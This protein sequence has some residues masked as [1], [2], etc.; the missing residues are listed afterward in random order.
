MRFLTRHG[1][2]ITQIGLIAGL[3]LSGLIFLWIGSFKMPDL[4]AF[5]QRKVPQ[6]TKIYDRTGEVLLYDVHED[7]R[8]TVIPFDKMSRHIKN[9]TVAIEDAEFYEHNGIKPTAILRAVLVNLVSLGYEQGGSTITQQVVKNSLLT[10]EKTIT[11]K[12]KEWVLALRLEKELPKDKILEIYLNEAPYGGSL[13]GIEE[14]SQAFFAKPAAELTLVESAYLAALPQ[15]PTYYSPY[16]NHLDKLEERKNLV[17]ESM[18]ENGFITQEEYEAALSE[19]ITFRD[20]PDTG[21]RAPHFVFYVLDKLREKYGDRAIEER[22]FRVIT[23]LDWELQEKAEQIVHDYAVENTEKF[24]ANNAG[25]AAVDPKTGQI[26]VMVG[27]RDYFDTTEEDGSAFADGNFN[28]TTGFRQPGSAFKPIVYATALKEGYTPE[29]VVFDVPTQFSTACE[30]DNFTSEGECYSPQNYDGEF[31]G[32]MTL[33]NALA[34]SV[35]VPAV[36]VLYLAGLRDALA[37]AKDLGIETLTT[38]SRYGLTLVLGGGEVTLLDLTSAYGVFANEGIR[39]PHTPILRIEDSTG[40]VVEE[41]EETSQRVLDESVALQ[42]SDILSD[43]IARTP[44]Y[45]ANS[46]LYFGGRDVAVKT[47]T[48]NEYV[49]VWT[50][51][52][53][54]SIAVGAWAGNNDSSSMDHQLSGLI[55]TPLWR[56]FMDEALKKYPSESFREPRFEDVAT[57]KPILRGVWQGGHTYYIDSESGKLASDYTPDETRQERVLNN[58]HSILYWVDKDNPRGPIPD[59]PAAD[60]QF[61][62]WEYGVAVWKA[63]AGIEDGDPDDIPTETDDVHAPGLVELSIESPEENSTFA[64]NDLLRISLTSSGENRLRRADYYVDGAFIGSS[65]RSPFSFSFVPSD[66]ELSKGS[67]TLKVIGKDSRSNSDEAT[68]TFHVN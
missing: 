60:P 30:P 33:R 32:P 34:Q 55:I 39:H 11:R 40:E 22:G 15:A 6:S 17:L 59:N 21:I 3:I 62:H 27:S 48:T 26:L 45:G 53:T 64:S 66:L 38:A 7:I 29:T 2:T 18:R 24:N 12:V 20:R 9:A 36:K 16:G 50:V 42:I 14:A 54:P 56:A 35:N 65:N 5:D 58:V 41:F 63:Q 57:L 68:L 28:V 8:R 23:T 13:Y 61:S 47:G 37:V 51:G 52:Y 31:R 25:L 44:L 1:R 4:E 43:N 67:H 46:L 19:K 10:Q 49:D